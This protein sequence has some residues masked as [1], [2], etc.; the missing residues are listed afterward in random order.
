MGKNFK[1]DI[2]QILQKERNRFISASE[3]ASLLK[4]SER[5]IYRH[6]KLLNKDLEEKGIKITS[7]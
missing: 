7:F 5:T 2:L 6:I 4:L 1:L 3:L